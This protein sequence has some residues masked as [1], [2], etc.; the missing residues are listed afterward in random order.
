MSSWGEWNAAELIFH[1][2]A[3]TA[4]TFA[5]GWLALSQVRKKLIL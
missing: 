4:F 1:L 2:V 3:L 5:L